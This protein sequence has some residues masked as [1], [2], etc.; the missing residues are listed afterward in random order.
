MFGIGRTKEQ[1]EKSALLEQQFYCRKNALIEKFSIAAKFEGEVDDFI[2][3]FHIGQEWAKL[4]EYA[5]G[6]IEFRCF[7]EEAWEEIDGVKRKTKSAQNWWTKGSTVKSH[8]HSD[9]DEYLYLVHGILEVITKDEYG[10][11]TEKTYTAQNDQPI[12]IPKGLKHYV[13][14]I[15]EVSFVA[16]FVFI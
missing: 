13:R 12:V 7:A 6:I 5:E 11:Y 14:A 16:K 9:A 10:V 2:V 15:T 3:D 1:K 4:T 8:Y